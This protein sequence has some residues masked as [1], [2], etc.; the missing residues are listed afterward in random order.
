M[1]I[2]SR[3]TV[4]H[5]VKQGGVLSPILFAVYM[6]GLFERLKDNGAGCYMC[7]HFVGGLG[8]ADDLTLLCPSLKGLKSMVKVCEE[9][10]DEFHV[11]LNGLKS[12]FLKV[13]GAARLTLLLGSMVL[14][15]EMC[16]QQS[17]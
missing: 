6:D 13:E 15:F 8:Y 12:K 2:S 5:G 4:S 16:S 3:F 1:H 9:Y 10:A 14:R 7:N 17:I 11:K